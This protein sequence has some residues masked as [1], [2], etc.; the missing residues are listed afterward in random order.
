MSVRPHYLD[1]TS[2]TDRDEIASTFGE[3]AAWEATIKTLTRRDATERDPQRKRHIR[4]L[5]LNAHTQLSLL[6]D[7]NRG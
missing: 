7:D 2:V 5:L 1:I 4:L 3:R 6:G